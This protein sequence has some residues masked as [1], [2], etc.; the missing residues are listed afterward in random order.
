MAYSSLKNGTLDAVII[1]PLPSPKVLTAS[2]HAEPISVP[3]PP[4]QR[5]VKTADGIFLPPCRLRKSALGFATSNPVLVGYFVGPT[6]SRRRVADGVRSS[7]TPNP[8]ATR[9]S[10]NFG[11]G[12]RA[13]PRPK[14]P[15][16]RFCAAG[17]SYAQLRNPAIRSP[18]SC[19][20][21]KVINA[22][23]GPHCNGRIRPALLPR[24][25]PR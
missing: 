25:W 5:T 12:T 21:S 19:S 6:L 10:P 4:A 2:S 13:L 22:Q 24:C 8:S 11:K 15:T 7:P 14:P 9:P 18:P 17:R 23:P 3:P 16:M 1:A 20:G